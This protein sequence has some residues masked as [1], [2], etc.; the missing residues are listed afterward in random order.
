MRPVNIPGI[1]VVGKY[2]G[3]RG[4]LIDVQCDKKYYLTVS[5]ETHGG[6]WQACDATS[7][8]ILSSGRT[9]RGTLKA[10]LKRWRQEIDAKDNK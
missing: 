7:G 1:V 10:T 2:K 3:R 8:E 4:R 6:I 9:V 5:V